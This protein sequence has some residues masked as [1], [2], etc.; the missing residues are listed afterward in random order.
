MGV[1]WI[2]EVIS[3]A[4][5]GPEYL[6]YI[7]DLGNTLQGVLIFVIFVWKQKIRRLLA[8]KF[9][10]KLARTSI[11]EGSTK[12]H[13]IAS[14]TSSINNTYR[15]SISTQDQL[16]LKPLPNGAYRVNGVA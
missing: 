7:T 2:M 12:S 5:G 15:T 1:N 16:V 9:F 8:K 4:V 11:Y 14:R 3:W 6:W 10:P 13:P